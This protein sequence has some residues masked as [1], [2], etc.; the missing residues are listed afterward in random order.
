MNLNLTQEQKE[1]IDNNIATI[2]EFANEVSEFDFFKKDRL[3]IEQEELERFIERVETI[4]FNI[5]EL[6]EKLKPFR[7]VEPARK[8]SVQASRKVS[9]KTNSGWATATKSRTLYNE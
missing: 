6:K 9:I 8:T 1:S 3:T 4:E 7:V 2:Y 5:K